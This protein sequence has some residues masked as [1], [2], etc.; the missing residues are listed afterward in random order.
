MPR[1]RPGEIRERQRR[2]ARTPQQVQQ[3]SRRGMPPP[4]RASRPVIIRS[5]NAESKTLMVQEVGPPDDD[6][7]NSRSLE[8]KGEPFRARP[9][10]GWKYEWFED[11]E[12]PDGDL[13]NPF[14]PLV[15]EAVWRGG[16]V[17]DV[18]FVDRFLPS[19]WDGSDGQ[20]GGS[21]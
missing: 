5:V 8:L 12:R 3:S 18:M 19:I 14:V 2:I 20:S 16:E 15:W 11:H 13:T 6:K 10:L 9:Y 17:W 4:S 1:L 21:G 7:W